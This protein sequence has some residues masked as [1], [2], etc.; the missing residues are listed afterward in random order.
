M[1]KLFQSHP[2]P[3]VKKK[4]PDPLGGVDRGRLLG[5]SAVPRRK[6]CGDRIRVWGVPELVATTLRHFGEVYVFTEPQ[7]VITSV[8]LGPA[9][10]G[11][12]QLRGVEGSGGWH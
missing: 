1:V 2:P 6:G 7:A 8:L 10:W 4:I 12:D 5:T 3:V 9:C 11:W